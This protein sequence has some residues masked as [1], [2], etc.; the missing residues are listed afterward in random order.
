[1]KAK[2]IN[3]FFLA[4]A[5]EL[6]LTDKE[7]QILLRQCN[8]ET[9]DE[10]S[11]MIEEA[12]QIAAPQ[13]LFAVSGIEMQGESAVVSG[14]PIASKLAAEKL[15]KKHRCFPYVMSC[16]AALEQW[17][18][19]YKGDFLTEY[20]AD[21]IKKMFL[22]KAGRE[23]FSFLKETYHTSGHLSALNPGSLE[24]SWPITG[25][26]ELFAIL[27]GPQFVKDTVGVYYTEGFLMVPSKSGSGIAF[28]S[29]V[30]YENCQYCPRT[31]C[32]NR[33]AKQIRNGENA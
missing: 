26:K 29:E 5:E 2:E 19:Q 10:F 24:H 8:E 31:D 30:F 1:M 17:S 9:Q 23:F 20:W 18:Q 12:G 15:G 6:T 7:R 27:G 33:R 11:D 22:A 32:P 25:Q 13:V 14:V 16:G 21:E 4:D 28:E 3:G